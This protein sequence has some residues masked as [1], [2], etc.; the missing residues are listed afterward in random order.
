M[1]QCCVFTEEQ[2][3]AIKESF[4]RVSE[5]LVKLGKGISKNMEKSKL[6]NIRTQWK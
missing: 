6:S 2:L 1:K 5:S 4:E 3:K